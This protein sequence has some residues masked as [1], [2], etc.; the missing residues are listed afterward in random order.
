MKQIN[1]RFEL[2]STLYDIKNEL[3]NNIECPLIIIDSLPATFYHT[4][5]YN[6]TL[7][8]MNHFVSI[9]R[10]ISV[11]LK[12]SFLL[13]NVMILK[14]VPNVSCSSSFKPGLGTYWVNVPSTR[15][16]IKKNNDNICQLTVL[17]STTI[18]CDKCCE[19]TITKYGIV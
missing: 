9:M 4:G 7:S 5:N 16:L 2:I 14:S 1:D 12:T 15:F 13:T 8:T 10:Y 17:K 11:E 6:S 3:L 18:E 19:V